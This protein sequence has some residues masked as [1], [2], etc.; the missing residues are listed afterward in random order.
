MVGTGI[1]SFIFVWSVGVYNSNIA[2]MKK[3]MR[4]TKY[5]IRLISFE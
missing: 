3:K 1:S 2:N 5:K 4:N